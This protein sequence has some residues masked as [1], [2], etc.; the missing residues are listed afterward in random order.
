MKISLEDS[1]I[2][3][4]VRET[5]EA[6]LDSGLLDQRLSYSSIEAARILDTTS[7][8]IDEARRSGRLRGVK[9]GKS[10]SYPR[11]ELLRFLNDHA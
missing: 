3:P 1:D 8:A 11:T 7:R 10:Y 6:M 2:T 9:I 4:I 5:V